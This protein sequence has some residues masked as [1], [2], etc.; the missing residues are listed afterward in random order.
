MRDGSRGQGA[1]PMLSVVM[2]A[3]N[4]A[5]Y[6]QGAVAAVVEG[7]RQR[8]I[9]FE[10]VV[11]ENG[12][13]D[14]TAARVALLAERYP[15]VV[16]V[17]LEVADY[18][19]ALRAGFMASR[20]ALVAN[21]DVDLVDL[22]FADHALKLIE[23]EDAAIVVGSKR[24]P[25]STDRRS[26]GRRLVTAV[27]SLVL[28]AGFGLLVSDT[29][30]MKLLRR[31]ALV[32]LVADCCFGGDIFDTEL[33]LRAERAGLVVAE[34]PV[35]VQDVRPP[36]TPI[37]RRIPRTLWGLVRLWLALRGEHGSDHRAD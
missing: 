27:F 20:G 4:E 8:G 23:Q 32:G 35:Q 1:T 6:I 30:G 14:A 26:L 13:V 3:H 16:S 7:L 28:R 22:D 36:R 34:I 18:G 31:Q 19:H 37:V 12:S 15:E 24:S 25:G 5:D 9:A 29:H 11:V 21:F 33:I 10:V 17:A 2:P